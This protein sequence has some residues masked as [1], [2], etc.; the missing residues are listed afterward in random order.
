MENIVRLA[1]LISCGLGL[2]AFEWSKHVLTAIGSGAGTR[3]IALI[4]TSL[5]R[6]AGIYDWG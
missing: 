5:S 4:P 3:I 6:S 2:S 1:A